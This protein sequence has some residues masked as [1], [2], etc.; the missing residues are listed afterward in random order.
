M[1]DGRH[2]AEVVDRVEDDADLRAADV[3]AREAHARDR[4]AE[5]E[6]AEV[7]QQIGMRPQHQAA[8][9][10][11]AGA[12]AA[13]GEEAELDAERAGQLTPPGRF[14]ADREEAAAPPG[15]RA[16]DRRPDREAF[17]QRHVDEV[18]GADQANPFVAGQLD[19]FEADPRMRRRPDE[20]RTLRAGIGQRRQ[21][22][23]GR[24]RSAPAQIGCGFSDG[25]RAGGCRCIGIDGGSRRPIIRA[26]ARPEFCR[27]SCAR[28][29]GRPA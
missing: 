10:R 9:G 14:A 1:R 3:A 13:T 18:A 28:R 11:C 26:I 24:Q 15:D 5:R 23:A 6:A 21:A 16:V 17:E 27:S 4:Q 25:R 20:R 19:A 2:V 29:S 8:A 12:A 22:E 7:P